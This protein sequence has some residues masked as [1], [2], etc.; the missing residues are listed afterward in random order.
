MSSAT[1]DST[2]YR[3]TSILDLTMNQLVT[4]SSIDWAFGTVGIPYSFALELRGDTKSERSKQ[5][6]GFMLPADQIE[7]TTFEL[8]AFVATLAKQI[9]SPNKKKPKNCTSKK[10]VKKVK[11]RKNRRLFSWQRLFS[12]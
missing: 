3:F 5:T 12:V 11:R 2:R 7:P 9:K 10:C 4:G 1:K 6:H 8:K